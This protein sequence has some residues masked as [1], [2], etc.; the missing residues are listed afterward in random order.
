MRRS[1]PFGC[2]FNIS[3]PLGGKF[4]IRIPLGGIS[5]ISFPVGGISYSSAIRWHLT[6]GHQCIVFLYSN[7]T[8]WRLGW[9]EGAG[10]WGSRASF[11]RPKGRSKRGEGEPLAEY[12]RSLNRIQAFPKPNNNSSN[13]AYAMER[14]RSESGVQ[15]TDKQMETNYKV[16]FKWTALCWWISD[17]SC[18]QQQ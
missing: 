7:T 1:L 10:G 9:G 15:G 14:D 8:R 17:I 6:L 4:D 2:I 13:D 5:N 16:F 18:H 12:V 3:R 11:G